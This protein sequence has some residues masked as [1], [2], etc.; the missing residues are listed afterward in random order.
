[1]F[2]T[3]FLIGSIFLFL[4]H[5]AVAGV[6]TSVMRTAN[7]FAPGDFELRAQADLILKSDLVSGSGAGFN[8]S[9]HLSTGLIEHLVDVDVYFGTGST[10]FIIGSTFQYNL[11]PDLE[12]QLGLSFLGELAF[13]QDRVR[14]FKAS[15]ALLGL[16]LL[17]SKKLETEF[18]F[19]APYAG[20]QIETLLIDGKNPTPSTL[21]AGSRWNF[22]STQPWNFYSELTLGLKESV[23]AIS[24]GAGQEF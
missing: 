13:L 8:L 2:R 7:V 3:S 18:G 5:R 23:L 19:A 4:T 9:P 22:H 20:Y 6:G 24:V 12:D 17:V 21:F 16:G 11:L 15:G 10:D 14:D 1:M